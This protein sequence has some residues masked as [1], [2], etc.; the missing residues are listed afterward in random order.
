M[1]RC[2]GL[3]PS[4]GPA[5]KSCRLPEKLPLAWAISAQLSAELGW[6]GMCAD[7][8]LQP[9][10]A[11][12]QGAHPFLSLPCAASGLVSKLCWPGLQPAFAGSQGALS[13]TVSESLF[14]AG[15]V[16]WLAA[17]TASKVQPGLLWPAAAPAS[18][19]SLWLSSTTTAWLRQLVLRWLRSCCS[20]PLQ[21]AAM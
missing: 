6:A 8:P 16:C 18:A 11:G 20:A 17:G 9:V 5:A 21:K 14:H 19:L 1:P 2:S 4:L 13:V 10:F 12:S 3:C 15:P 7:S